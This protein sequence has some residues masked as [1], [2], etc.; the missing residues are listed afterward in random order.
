MD[1]RRIKERLVHLMCMVALYDICAFSI[2]SG[3]NSIALIG[4]GAFW[5]LYAV[6]TF[7]LIYRTIKP[8]IE[9]CFYG[10]LE[11]ATS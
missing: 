9:W 1:I 11:D 5:I 4:W 7:I 6:S 8:F 10:H 3:F 2:L